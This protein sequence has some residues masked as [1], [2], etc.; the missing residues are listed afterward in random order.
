MSGNCADTVNSVLRGNRKLAMPMND[1]EAAKILLFVQAIQRLPF[2]T[3]F[4]FRAR[5]TSMRPVI[6]DGDLVELRKATTD[7]ARPGDIVVFFQSPQV[8]CHRLVRKR[9]FRHSWF[10]QTQGDTLWEK[11]HRFAPRDFLGIITHVKK[12]SGAA[13]SFDR[14]LALL[15]R[16]LSLAL[17]LLK[18]LFQKTL[19]GVGVSADRLYSSGVVRAGL[20][21]AYILFCKPFLSL[22]TTPSTEAPRWGA[23]PEKAKDGVCVSG[24][25]PRWGADPESTP[26]GLSPEGG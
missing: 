18:A 11:D 21:T 6:D 24:Q 3:R 1:A 23:D 25:A 2:H 9:R 8:L 5:G 13:I 17:P 19:L 22:L 10:F 7:H 14:P 16:P 4:S 15:L 12:P 26:L 20:K